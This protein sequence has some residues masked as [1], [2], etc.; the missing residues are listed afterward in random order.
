MGCPFGPAVDTWSVGVILLELL[1]GRPLFDTARSRAGLLQQ[2]MCAFGPMPLRRFR[3]G[4][5]FSE[6]FPQDQSLQV[7]RFKCTD[8]AG[9]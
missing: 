6:Y 8:C 2:T 9:R 1:L 7:S 3:V 4:H 5:Y